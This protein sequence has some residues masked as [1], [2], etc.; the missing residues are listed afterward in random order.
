MRYYIINEKTNKWTL[1]TFT[2]Q[3]M[4]NTF[5][6]MYPTLKFIFKDETLH[7]DKLRLDPMNYEKYL[8]GVV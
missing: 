5:K 2:H 3:L 4:V 7:G 6:Q 1:M 8:A